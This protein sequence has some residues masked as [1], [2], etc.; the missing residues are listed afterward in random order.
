MNITYID[1]SPKTKDSTSLYLLKTLESKMP[2]GYLPSWIDVRQCQIQPLLNLF[3][4]SDIIVI[5]F[6]LY[7]DSIPSHLLQ[8]LEDIQPLLSSNPKSVRLY[9]IVNCGFYDTRQNHIALS[10]MKVW[11]KKSGFIW[12]QGVAAGGGGMAQA[13]P[14]GRG[15]AGNLGKALDDLADNII[16]AR[17]SDDLYFEPNFPRFLYK[18]AAHLGWINQA[19]KNNLKSKNLHNHHPLLT[20]KE[21]NFKLL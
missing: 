10:I 12:G 9:T 8:M 14:A 7:V 16:N 11:C 4:K 18:A 17:T 5:A 1:G 3:E 20:E 6:P 15:P 21:Q 2:E 19:K 13:A